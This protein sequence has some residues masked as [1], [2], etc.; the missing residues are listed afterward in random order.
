MWSWNQLTSPKSIVN[1]KIK[2]TK[3]WLNYEVMLI[4][5]R[6]IRENWYQVDRKSRSDKMS[7][8]RNCKLY[9]FDLEEASAYTPWTTTRKSGEKN[10]KYAWSSNLSSSCFAN[11]LFALNASRLR[12]FTVRS[13]AGSRLGS[14]I[15]FDYNNHKNTLKFQR[16]LC[17]FDVSNVHR[18]LARFV[19]FLCRIFSEA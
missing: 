9:V 8:E 16:P 4:R 17:V 1:L 7:R 14:I 12:I 18:S 10:A 3:T 13:S 11:N 19:V 5:A 2:L 6:K 15:P